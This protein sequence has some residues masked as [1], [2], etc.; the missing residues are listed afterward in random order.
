MSDCVKVMVDGEVLHLD[1]DQVQKLI[2][3]VNKLGVKA[4]KKLGYR[5]KITVRWKWSDPVLFLSTEETEEHKFERSRKYLNKFKKHDK[6][7]IKFAPLA[8]A[9]EV[10]DPAWTALPEEV[11]FKMFDEKEK[12]FKK[13]CEK[14]ERKKNER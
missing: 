2:N 3:D 1:G 12:R 8:E 14:K 13:Y 6:G 11:A 10:Y 5:F 9:F 7:K 4:S